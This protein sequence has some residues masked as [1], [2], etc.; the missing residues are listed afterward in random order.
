M[1]GRITWKVTR[2]SEEPKD[3]EERAQKEKTQSLIDRI[4]KSAE[5]KKLSKESN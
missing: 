3:G 2:P 5:S 1:S 4:R